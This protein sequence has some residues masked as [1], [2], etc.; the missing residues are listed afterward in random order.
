MK[1]SAGWWRDNRGT[2]KVWLDVNWPLGSGTL[3]PLLVVQFGRLGEPLG[4]ASLEE[5][6]HLGQAWRLYSFID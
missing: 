5:E 2:D 1:F 6:G 3:C 4:I